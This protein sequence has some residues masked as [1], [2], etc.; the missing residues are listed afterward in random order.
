[1]TR[2]AA[3]E[4]AL[5]FPSSSRKVVSRVKSVIQR[6]SRSSTV[7]WIGAAVFERKVAVVIE[8]SSRNARF[9]RWVP[10][11]HRP[12]ISVDRAGG[13]RAR[14]MKCTSREP[15]I[16]PD[17]TLTVSTVVSERGWCWKKLLRARTVCLAVARRWRDLSMHRARPLRRAA[18]RNIG[19]V[20]SDVQGRASGSSRTRSARTHGWRGP[21]RV[22]RSV[23]A[24]GNTPR[25]GAFPVEASAPRASARAREFARS[26]VDSS[27][28]TRDRSRRRSRA[29]VAP[30]DGVL[31]L[32]RL[33]DGRGRWTEPAIFHPR[34]LFAARG[35]RV[36]DGADRGRSEARGVPDDGGRAERSR[37]QDPEPGQGLPHRYASPPIT[38][39]ALP[40]PAARPIHLHRKK[41]RGRA[42]GLARSNQP[43]IDTATVDS[44]RTREMCSIFSPLFEAFFADWRPVVFGARTNPSSFS[45]D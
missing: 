31:D 36:Q 40:R 45:A 33:H 13:P 22:S 35:R 10:I 30:Q 24:R 41:P 5:L 37:A 27:R 19:R 29:S 11:A 23:S 28:R 20:P 38:I 34:A 8:R 7:R 16:R 14:G 15:S 44:I 1:M 12:G 32:P 25:L 9:H 4:P 2:P 39:H 43:K 21:P 18:A 6:S 26:R 17:E 42:R 3:N